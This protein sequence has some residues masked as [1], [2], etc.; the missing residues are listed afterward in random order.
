MDKFTVSDLS[1][2]RQQ[3]G[4][5]YHEFLRVPAMS[6]GLYEL[7]AGANDPQQPHTED[8]LYYVVRGKGQ[9]RVGEEDALVE[10]GSL[11][12]VAANV[13]HRFHSITEDLSIV[14]F[15]APA[16]YSLKERR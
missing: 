8:E 13:E 6:A 16:E 7:A 3:S 5:L 4:K 1:A 14:V 2:A 10:A 15:F 9:I 11:I 12:F